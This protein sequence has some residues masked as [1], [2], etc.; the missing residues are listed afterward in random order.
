MDPNR[1]PYNVFFLPSSDKYLE[2]KKNGLKLGIVE[3]YLFSYKSLDFLLFLYPHLISNGVR[4]H[5][6]ILDSF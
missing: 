2:Y 6:I 1:F 3:S 5:V 4:F